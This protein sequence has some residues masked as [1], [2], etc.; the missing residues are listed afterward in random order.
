[1]NSQMNLQQVV[2]ATVVIIGEKFSVLWDIKW[3][4]KIHFHLPFFVKLFESFFGWTIYRYPPN[5]FGTPQSQHNDYP[6]FGYPPQGGFGGPYSQFGPGGFPGSQHYPANGA[7]GY[8]GQFPV[9]GGSNDGVAD[10]FLHFLQK[11]IP[12][13]LG[14]PQ[15]NN[16]ANGLLVGPGG[17]TGIIGRPGFSPY[18]G[19][20]GYPGGGYSQHPGSGYSQH[21]GSGYSQHPGYPPRQPFGFEGQHNSLG[22][23]QFNPAFGGGPGGFGQGINPYGGSINPYNQQFG[24][25]PYGPYYDS[26]GKNSAVKKVEKSAKSN[27]LFI[28]FSAMIVILLLYIFK[29]FSSSVK[30][31][32]V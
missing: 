29:T 31:L 15:Q 26:Q 7:S 19:A 32:Y 30:V 20:G 13:P 22:G 8:P 9:H 28:E 10:I 4:L 24:G 25:N 1:M 14:Y 18:Q 3:K 27:W 12:G 11:F 23:G 21:P 2:R 6:G 16:L 5:R 17:P